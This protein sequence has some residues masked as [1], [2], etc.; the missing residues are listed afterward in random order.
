MGF[1]I[2]KNSFSFVSHSPGPYPE[3]YFGGGFD[4]N[5]HYRYSKIFNVNFYQVV[6]AT[7]TLSGKNITMHVNFFFFVTAT[8]VQW[9][10]T[11]GLGGATNRFLRFSHK[12][13]SLKH[14]LY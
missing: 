11:G 1:K 5:I 6:H 9:R 4:M 14:T 10:K 12:K 2:S 13:H 3:K 7:L 8:A